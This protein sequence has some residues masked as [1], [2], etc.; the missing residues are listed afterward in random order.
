MVRYSY[1]PDILPYKMLPRF[2]KRHFHSLIIPKGAFYKTDY[3]LFY[4]PMSTFAPNMQYCHNTS[5]T[6][7]ATA[8]QPLVA[9]FSR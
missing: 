6:S 5:I 7:F 3:F 2:D 8:T 4:G 9:P 1:F